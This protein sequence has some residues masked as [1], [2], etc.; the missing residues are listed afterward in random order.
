MYYLNIFPVLLSSLIFYSLCHAQNNCYGNK[1]VT[2]YC[3]PLTYKDT[4]GIFHA[5]PRTSDCQDTCAGINEDLGDWLVDFSMDADGVRHSM[6]L[7]HC[8]FAV[9]QGEGTPHNTKFSLANQDILDLYDG[10]INRFGGLHNGKISA[11]GTMQCGKFQIKWYI[12]DL[13]AQSSISRY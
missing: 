6:I 2:G 1:S 12:Q 10:A 8:G 5:P 11:E 7:Y 3:T 9:S 13:Y 4:T